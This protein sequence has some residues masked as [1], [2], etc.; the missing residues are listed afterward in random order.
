[1]TTLV[2]AS[3][4]SLN[5][6]A[7]AQN[8]ICTVTDPTGTPLNVRDRP[9]GKVINSLRNGRDVDILDIK[10]DNRGRPWARVAGYHNNRYR[11]WG[12]VIREFIS[13]Y[14]S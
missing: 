3:T 5:S 12:W 11:V 13:C 10:S 6:R 4:F 8:M 7:N 2:F 14:E 1:M 9:N